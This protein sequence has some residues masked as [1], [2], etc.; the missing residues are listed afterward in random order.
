MSEARGG[1]GPAPEHAALPPRWVHYLAVATAVLTF[2][3]ICAGGLVKS[4]KAGLSVPDWPLSYGQPQQ[5]IVLG[6]FGGT[7]LLGLAW[8]VLRK[9]ALAIG[10]VLC[11][12]GLAS[13]YYFFGPMPG[14]IHVPNVSAEHGHRLLAG[15]V[16][17]MTAVLAG[18]LWVTD[19]RAWVRRLGV[20]ALIAVVVQAVL[21]GV[22]VHLQLPPLVSASH[23]SLAQAF[24]AMLV[25]LAVATAPGWFEERPLIPQTDRK[26]LQRLTRMMVGAFY[27]QVI[28]GAAVRHAEYYPDYTDL[29][30]KFMW[31]LGAHL[32]GLLWVAHTFGAVLVR[33]IRRHGEEPAL[34]RPVSLL[35]MLLGAQ[36]LLGI[37]ALFIRLTETEYDPSALKLL[38][39]TAHVAGGAL[40]L[41]TAV[42]IMLVAH[43]RLA[44]AVAQGEGSG[45]DAK[46]QLAQ[47]GTAT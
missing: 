17:F 24:F 22:T 8:V 32:V 27:L 21:G 14:W 35:T 28:L 46:T 37:G 31:H 11:G 44:P 7:L 33:V 41:V 23:G 36:I 40:S 43:R 5:G 42:W 4:L 20:V 47:T 19:R 34:M 30:A 6:L 38:V 9:K 10:A 25:T 29:S 1:I 15:T 18:A 13:T 2:V 16:G 45:K 3:L 26:P 12:T 39:R